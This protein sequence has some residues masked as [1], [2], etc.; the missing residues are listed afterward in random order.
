MLR[1]KLMKN[2]KITTKDINLIE[3]AHSPDISAIKKVNNNTTKI[4]DIA[5]NRDS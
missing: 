4:S 1:V 2:V 5:G 3:K